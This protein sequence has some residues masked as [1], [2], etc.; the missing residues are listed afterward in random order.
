MRQPVSV[1][2]DQGQAPAFGD[3][4]DAVQVVADVVH[5]H[6]EMTLAPPGRAAPLRHAEWLGP[7]SA[8]SCTRG[9]SSAG[10]VCKVKRLLPPDL[11]SQLRSASLREASPSARPASSAGCRSTCARQRWS[12]S[13]PSSPPSSALVRTWISRSLA[14]SSICGP[15]FRIST[16]ARIGK[17]W[18]RS[19]MPATACKAARNLSWAR[20][21][22]NHFN[23]LNLIVVVSRLYRLWR[24]A[25]SLLRTRS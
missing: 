2:R 11:S 17:V 3:E 5:R 8:D 15:V 4:Q 24:T 10:I 6:R 21:Q 23:L 1:G 19:T 9:K 22:D 25:F 7:K 20:F 12:R 13:S 14:V 18:R 16:L